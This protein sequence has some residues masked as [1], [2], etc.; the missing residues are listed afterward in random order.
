MRRILKIATVLALSA[1]LIG[2][3]NLAYR[4]AVYQ[5]NVSTLTQSAQSTV[6]LFEKAVAETLS[7]IDLIQ[8]GGHDDCWPA[9][10]RMLDEAVF[11][12]SYI[13]DILV[14]KGG[15]TCSS[16]G[17]SSMLM[18]AYLRHDP[19]V[20]RETSDVTFHHVP[21]GFPGIA[22]SRGFD[23]EGS[24]VAAL[25]NANAF[26]AA[27]IDSE[28]EMQSS[29]GI[30]A[31][32]GM[33][34]VKTAGF[35]V[36]GADSASLRIVRASN[37]YPFRVV[38][39]IPKSV[40]ATGT[41]SYDFWTVVL[42]CLLALAAAWTLTSKFLLPDRPSDFIRDAI[43]SG[44]IRPYLQPIVD[45]RTGRIEGFEILSR[46]VKPTGYVVG[47][48]EFIAEVERYSLSML[49]LR[50]LAI[51]TGNAMDK[52]ITQHPH[53]RFAFNVP[54]DAFVRP[55]FVSHFL[56][57]LNMAAIDPSG[58]TVEVTERQEIPDVTQAR[59]AVNELQ[60][61]GV[62]VSID[63]VGTGH[64]GLSVIAAIAPNVIKID[65]YFVDGLPDNQRARSMVEMLV[66]TAKSLGMRTVA[67]GV[68]SQEQVQ[69]LMALGVDCGQGY[70]IAKPMAPDRAIALFCRHQEYLDAAAA[71]EAFTQVVADGPSKVTGSSRPVFVAA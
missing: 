59:V 62:R 1:I 53:L 8:V 24:T 71:H 15:A 51:Q 20:S 27:T 32:D 70:H 12:S 50:S 10:R 22:I 25:I 64:N 48:S 26:A 33:V 60:A 46:W 57:S 38:V 17:D 61:A 41:V 40:A 4:S 65:K 37:T 9:S 7:A 35:D 5:S 47:P 16:S 66:R 52:L 67:E 11:L 68:E 29:M 3:V 39:D 58:A 28:L 55:D 36:A 43:K 34:I 19:K 63:D 54:P 56:E 14:S 2:I 49:L 18:D 69:A 23:R 21:V 30:V 31:D 13:K 45:L 42:V 6:R 44:E